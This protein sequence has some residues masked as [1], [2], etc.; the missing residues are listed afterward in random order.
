M[1]GVDDLPGINAALNGTAAL[2]LATGWFAIR[3]KRVTFHKRCMVAA[4]ATSTLFL[5][6]YLTHKALVH[7]HHTPFLGEGAARIVYFAI[8]ISH[9]V[10]A[11]VIVPLAI[12]TL[13][14]GLRGDLV[15]HKKLARIT[16]PIW[17]YVSVTG[18]VVWWMLYGGA[19]GPAGR[20]S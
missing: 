6:T 14:R 13:R 5:C 9:T 19:F 4:F 20:P 17:L 8:L 1:I 12:V 3:S 10:L 2:L 7:G 11:V 18:V 16:L 15:R